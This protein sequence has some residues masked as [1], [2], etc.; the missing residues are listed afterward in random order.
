VGEGG[1]GPGWRG[2]LGRLN[3]VS[4]SFRA[5]SWCW[6]AGASLI[7]EKKVGRATFWIANG[8]CKTKGDIERNAIMKVEYSES[9]R[10]ATT[11]SARTTRSQRRG[12][13][14]V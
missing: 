5:H 6:F 10:T 9:L 11:I 7:A 12:T 1:F 2:G 14:S 8:G 13:E 3:L 4:R